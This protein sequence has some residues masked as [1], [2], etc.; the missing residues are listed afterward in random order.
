[1][2][3]T[4]NNA[5]V[6]AIDENTDW[7][8]LDNILAASAEYQSSH[9]GKIIPLMFFA[10]MMEPENLDAWEP[11]RSMPDHL[12]IVSIERSTDAVLVRALKHAEDE[13]GEL[14]FAASFPAVRID[15]E[16]PFADIYQQMETAE[17]AAFASPQPGPDDPSFFFI[18]GPEAVRAFDRSLRAVTH[19]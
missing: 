11:V 10:P 5:P 14:H 16:Q 4:A 13:L 9:L 12:F 15:F 2:K 3:P 1:M 7:E 19:S 8:D 18:R 6:F 17:I